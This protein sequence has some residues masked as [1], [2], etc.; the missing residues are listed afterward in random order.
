VLS[1]EENE[2]LTRVGAATPMGRYVRRFWCPVL[3]ADELVA[4]GQPK[5]VQLM[6]ERLVAFRDTDGRVGIMDEACPHRGASLA[7]GRNEKCG[8]RCLYHGW[9]IDVDGTVVDTPAE[10][11]DSSL[12]HRF[13]HIAYPVREQGGLIWTYI[14]PPDLI[15]ALP[16]YE[17]CDLPADQ[18]YVSRV[19]EECNWVQSLEGVI[20]PPHASFLHSDT[21]GA[22]DDLDVPGRKEDREVGTSGNLGSATRDGRPRLEVVNTDYGFKIAAI[23]RPVLDPES[24][25]HV[26]VSHYVAP[27]LGMFPA[28]DGWG[29]LQMFVPMDDEHTM[30]FFIAYKTTGPITDVER[31]ELDLEAGA[32]IGIDIDGDFRKLRTR[33]NNWLQDREAM[34]RGDSFAGLEGIGN[35][36]MVVQESMGPIYDRSKE[37]LGTGDLAVIRMRRLMLDAARRIERGD[38]DGLLGLDGDIAYGAIRAT[39]AVVPLDEPWDTESAASAR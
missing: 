17:W 35:E 36:D 8:L 24:R 15:G 31:E 6:G 7:L 13:R 27:F 12:K 32:R 29:N 2:L 23:R 10:P 19:Q 34:S 4:D 9:K 21:F 28:G 26:R 38:A 37:H 22:P 39:D 11:L 5:R 1:T 30:Q 33:E 25:K 3:L 16:D 14:G 20:D 18:V